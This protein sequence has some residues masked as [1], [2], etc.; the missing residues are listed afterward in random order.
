MGGGGGGKRCIDRSL[1]NARRVN[2]IIRAQGVD[3]ELWTWREADGV[4]LSASESE[5]RRLWAEFIY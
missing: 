4:G 3:G 2:D 1:G 5:G